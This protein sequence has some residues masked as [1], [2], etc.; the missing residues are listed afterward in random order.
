VYFTR[1][2]STETAPRP[3]ADRLTAT[4]ETD[5]L[6]IDHTKPEILEATAR[7]DG[8][9]LIISVSGRDGLS[10]LDGVEIIFNN[11]VREVVEQPDDGV[12]DSRQERFTLD[13]PLAK[14]STATAA[15]VTLYDSAGNGTPK[16]LSW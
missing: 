16:R 10:L 3:V 13:I 12:R 5:D 6:V 15:E 14:V 4:F 8:D 2:V 11:G 1:L 9:R 7:R